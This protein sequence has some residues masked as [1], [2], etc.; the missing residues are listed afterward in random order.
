MHTYMVLKYYLTESIYQVV[1]QK[2]I[3]LRIRQLV[4]YLSDNKG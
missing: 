4:L 3:P 2:S 1:L